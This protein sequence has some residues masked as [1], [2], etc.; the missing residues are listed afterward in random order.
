MSDCCDIKYTYTY[1]YISCRIRYSDL[2]VSDIIMFLA[3]R[4][5]IYLSSDNDVLWIHFKFDKNTALFIT[6]R[7]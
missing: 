1:I 2:G 7:S 4:Y 6:R 5:I 3:S